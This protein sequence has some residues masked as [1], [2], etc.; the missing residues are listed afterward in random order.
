MKTAATSFSA[1]FGS[2]LAKTFSASALAQDDPIVIESSHVVADSTPNCQRG[3]KFTDVAEELLPGS[4]EVQVFPHSQLFGDG[5]ELEALL[6]GDVQILAPSLSKF[7]RYRPMLQIFD[8]PFL[9]DDMDD[10]DRFQASDA[11]Q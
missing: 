8:L 5:R 6:L 4:V 3:I 10:V 2:T 9:F 1:I 7:D 11:G